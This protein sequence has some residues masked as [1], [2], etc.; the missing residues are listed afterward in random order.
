MRLKY[1]GPNVGYADTL[2]D[3]VA[4]GKAGFNAVAINL[5]KRDLS[6]LR[7]FI[8]K[9]HLIGIQVCGRVVGGS[10]DGYANPR[11]AALDYVTLGCDLL[12]IGNETDGSVDVNIDGSW[13]QSKN[14]WERMR[15]AFVDVFRGTTPMYGPGTVTGDPEKLRPFTLG[16]LT[17][18]DNHLYTA[19]PDTIDDM[20]ESYDQFDNTYGFKERLSSEWG[21]PVPDPEQR[22]QYV[23]D[24]I[25]ATERMNDFRRVPLVGMFPYCWDDVQ[26]VQD[27]YLNHPTIISHIKRLGY[28][29]EEVPIVP[30][31]I[32]PV[33]NFEFVLGVKAKAAELRAKGIDVGTPLM[34]ERYPWEGVDF[35]YQ[36]TTTGKFEWDTIAQVVQFYASK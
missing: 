27:F 26:H 29:P 18:V 11:E 36:R 10:L 35:S 30:P 6:K 32:A 19:T 5:T 17:G 8:A 34:H 16:G 23:Y 28:G 14:D 3:P 33:N 9:C 31:V 15:E 12:T 2:F 21:W 24:L 22:G 4:I 7:I 1:F 20:L 13:I 25:R